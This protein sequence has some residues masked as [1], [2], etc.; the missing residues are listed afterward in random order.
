MSITAEVKTYWNRQS[1]GTDQTCAPKFLR[2][3]FDD[4]E[5][6]PPIARNWLNYRSPLQRSSEP[7]DN[8]KQPRSPTIPIAAMPA[9]KTR[10]S[11]SRD[12]ESHETLYDRSRNR[13]NISPGKRALSRDGNIIAGSPRSAGCANFHSPTG[14]PPKRQPTTRPHTRRQIAAVPCPAAMTG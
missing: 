6:F 9:S 14:S 10:I 1:C 8:I 5:R 12:R 13:G 7:E 3:Y 11:I 2:E 4:V